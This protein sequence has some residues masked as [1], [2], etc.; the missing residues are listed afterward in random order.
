MRGFQYPHSQIYGQ[1]N[2]IFQGEFWCLFLYIVTIIFKLCRSRDTTRY[3]R[4]P[5]P[6]AATQICQLQSTEPITLQQLSR[7]SAPR[8][9]NLGRARKMLRCLCMCIIWISIMGILRNRLIST[10]GRC[11]RKL[12]NSMMILMSLWCLSMRRWRPRGLLAFLCGMMGI[13]TNLIR[14]ILRRRMWLEMCTS[15]STRLIRAR[16][17]QKRRC[18]RNH[19]A[20]RRGENRTK[21]RGLNCR[22]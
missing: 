16:S 21:K 12:L 10:I 3:P 14:E 18:I 6:L 11:I 1:V 20:N 22:R 19:T 15:I 4:K 13:S 2:F 17:S 9:L 8:Y 5:S 7:M